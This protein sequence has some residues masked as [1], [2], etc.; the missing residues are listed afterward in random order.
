M[1]YIA[2]ADSVVAIED[3]LSKG[4]D[5]IEVQLLNKNCDEDFIKYYE[6]VY[7]IHSK[8]DKDDFNRTV[9]LEDSDDFS[10]SNLREAFELANKIGERANRRIGVIIHNGI[11]L[12]KMEKLGVM[13]YA[14]SKIERL[15]REFECT[16]LFIENP[17][18]ACTAGIYT[19]DLESSELIEVVKELKRRS[20]CND[21]IY[22]LLDTVHAM[23]SSRLLELIYGYNSDKL[24]EKY[25][26]D[27][28]EFTKEIHFANII[29]KGL[30]NHEHGVAFREG[31]PDDDKYFEMTLRLI[32]KYLINA[33]VCLEIREEDYTNA[34]N[35]ENTL[36]R[37]KGANLL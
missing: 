18:I 36:K 32:K 6:K 37:I 16:E 15:L 33:N 27:Y 23:A 19:S 21:R 30:S 10:L 1:K 14:F 2:K 13:N 20:T 3:K 8:L 5:W 22:S 28:A 35:F 4:A 11:G 24:Y 29:N 7:S 17:S 34:V 9:N 25:F 26:Q 12:D 31:N